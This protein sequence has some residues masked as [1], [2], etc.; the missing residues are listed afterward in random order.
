M[1]TKK[2]TKSKGVFSFALLIL[3]I[4]WKEQKKS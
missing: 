4:C 1:R 2:E 3:R